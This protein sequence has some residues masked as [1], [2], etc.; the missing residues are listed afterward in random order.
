MP[1]RVS[2]VARLIMDRPTCLDCIATKSGLTTREAE[3]TL[4]A[5]DDALRVFREPGLCRVC[6]ETKRVFSVRGRRPS[7]P[8][9]Q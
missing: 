9:P 7:P 5:I 4:T 2:I 6:E 3:E 1:D 8:R